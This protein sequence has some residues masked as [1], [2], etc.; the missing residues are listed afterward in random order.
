[1]IEDNNN[2]NDNA[3]CRADSL[4][5]WQVWLHP[6][7]TLS[8]MREVAGKIEKMESE[9]DNER[10]QGEALRKENAD[11]RERLLASENARLQLQSELLQMRGEQEYQEEMDRKLE[12]LEKEFDRMEEMKLKYESSISSLRRRLADATDELKRISGQSV[13]P[14][15]LL[16]DLKRDDGAE[17]MT[18]RKE[19]EN[20]HKEVED[21]R[22]RLEEEPDYP[23]RDKKGPDPND[24]LV[25]LPDNI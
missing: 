24:W 17:E 10:I 15:D 16:A 18:P 14:L 1:M 20:N 8:S 23:S 12:A 9:L 2:D 25:S 6:R 3:A 22:N 5:A 19:V 4:T 7:R 21:K 11:L 13:E